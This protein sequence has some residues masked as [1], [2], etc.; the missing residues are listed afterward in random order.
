MKLLG[1]QIERDQSGSV[2]LVPEEPEDIWHAYNLILKGDQLTAVTTRGVK[3]ESATGSVST[4]RV[5]L[6]LTVSIEDV[7]FDSYACA[8]RING[9][10]VAENPHVSIGQYHTLDL[11]LNQPFTL[12]KP[13]WDVISLQR[14]SDACDIA[15]QA[16]AAAVTMHEGLAVICLMTQH[17]TVVRQRIEVAIPRKSRGST[18]NYDK[19]LQ[20]FY[21]QVYE[22][23]KRHIDF[24]V[25]KVVILG[26]PGFVREQFFAY[27][28]A[29]AAKAEDR[30][31]IENKAK[32]LLVHTS[33]GHKGALEEVMRDPQI[34]VRLAD[35]K[36]AV[37]ARAIDGFYQML[38]SNPDRAFYGYDDVAKA[39]ENGAIGTLMVTDEL[40]RAA[41]VPTRK[42]YIR[43]VEDS[44]ASN[45]EVLVFSSMHVSGEQLNQLSGVAAILNFPLLIESDD[46]C[47]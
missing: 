11:E 4:N 19:G 6:K 28:M 17:M 14:V 1:R 25:V 33:S 9:R 31:I 5:R 3:S 43:L 45:A 13:E 37:E 20:R 47:E 41:D 39:A 7:F 22:A 18:T 27:M 44:K 30:A 10:V 23:I 34:R 29:Q 2:R 8:L 24:S 26:S 15:R 40:F 16:D 38:N 46:E 32:F 12:A 21:E 36:S 42:K 35:T